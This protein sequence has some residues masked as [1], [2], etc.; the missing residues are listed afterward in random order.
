MMI[1]LINQELYH[2]IRNTHPTSIRLNCSMCLC[3]TSMFPLQ[4]FS[5]VEMLGRLGEASVAMVEVVLVGQTEFLSQVSPGISAAGVL[6]VLYS[7]FNDLES[8]SSNDSWI[9]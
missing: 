4:M 8:I 9:F 5:L 7:W 3:L 6:L 2:Y 1:T